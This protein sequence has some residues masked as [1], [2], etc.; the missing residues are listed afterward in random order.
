MPIPKD[1]TGQRFGRLIAIE[2]TGKR[3]S[4]GR[5]WRARCDC[6]TEVEYGIGSMTSGNTS[7]CGCLRTE[8]LVARTQTH[9][10]AVRAGETAEYN[11]WLNAKSRCFNPNNDDFVNYGAR[12]ITMC[13]TWRD[14]FT[15][16]LCDMGTRPAGTTL[17]RID[18]NGN[19]E[20]GNC[21]WA[22]TRQQAR[23]RTDNIW[24]VHDGQRMILTDFAKAIG[25][26]YSCLHQRIRAH[27]CT[28]HEAAAMPGLKRTRHR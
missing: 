4:Q 27:N 26:P 17:D 21:R 11:A 23:N 9:G 19:Y 16:F 12:G 7:S 14:D 28:P 15:A 22:T 6:G 20:P 25:V 24:V 5:V 3:G 1:I 2:W 10:H 18:V 13:S 8:Q